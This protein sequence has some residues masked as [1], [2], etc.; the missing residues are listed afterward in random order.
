MTR[1]ADITALIDTLPDAPRAV[2]R[3]LR[4]LIHDTASSAD[5]P[6]TEALEWGQPSF[7]PPNASARR[8]A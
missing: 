4:A 8:S 1:S 7:A 3:A 6:V 5:I 2:M